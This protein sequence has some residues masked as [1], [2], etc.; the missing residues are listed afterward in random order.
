MTLFFDT[1]A[2][3]KRYIDE[4]GSAEVENLCGNADDIGISIIL[5]IEA[6]ST[7]SRLRREKRLTEKQYALLKHEL[8][9]DLRDV[10]VV[11][12][13]PAIVTAAIDALE[14]SILK[15]LDAI[16]IACALEYKPDFFVSS[17]AQQIVAATKAG[18]SVK[19]VS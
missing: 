5:P 18:L 14:N 15:S 19:K 11:T 2:F 3:V 8:F 6:L 1:S 4:T 17:D 16:H 10:T 7:F 9:S 12:L 13:S